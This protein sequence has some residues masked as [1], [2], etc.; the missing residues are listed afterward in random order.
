MKLPCRIGQ[1]ISHGT[2]F[3]IITD[4]ALNAELPESL[5]IHNHQVTVKNGLIYKIIAGLQM[6][7]DG[8]PFAWSDHHVAAV[9]DERNRVVWTNPGLTHTT[10]ILIKVW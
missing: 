2:F 3:L 8:K 7:A 9:L 5:S 4:D 10:T 6:V 1:L